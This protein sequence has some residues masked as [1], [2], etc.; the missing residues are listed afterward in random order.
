MNGRREGSAALTGRKNSLDAL[1]VAALTFLAADEERL[2][3]FI[4]ASGVG[5][6]DLRAAASD[7]GFLRGVLAHVASDDIVLVAF[8]ASR[9]EPPERLGATIASLLHGDERS[10]P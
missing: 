7:P 9:G 10:E 3:D 4:A 6:G 5:P 2:H 8:A 1:G